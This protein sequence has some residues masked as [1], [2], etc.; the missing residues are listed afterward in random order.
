VRVKNCTICT[1][2]H[3]MVFLVQCAAPKHC[4]ICTTTLGEWCNWCIWSGGSSISIRKNFH[5]HKTEDLSRSSTPGLTTTADRLFS[6]FPN[7]QHTRLRDRP[8]EGAR[9]SRAD[10][11]IEGSSAGNALVRHGSTA[12]DHDAVPAERFLDC[13]G[14]NRGA[15]VCRE[16]AKQ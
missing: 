8:M 14:S 10:A 12:A 5:A 9:R 15:A 11:R 16:G 13:W 4:T 6:R 2:L 3:Q 7:W 1:K